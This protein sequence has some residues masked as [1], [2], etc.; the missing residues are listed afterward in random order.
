MGEEEGEKE[1]EEEGEKEGEEEGEEE[2]EKE[3]EEEERWEGSESQGQQ[4]WICGERGRRAD[5][6]VHIQDTHSV[7]VNNVHDG[8]RF[9]AV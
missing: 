5:L 3:G 8:F 4:S 7:R 9:N 6:G 1:G 2:G